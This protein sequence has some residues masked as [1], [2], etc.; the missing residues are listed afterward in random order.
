MSP[1]SRKKPKD[2][3]PRPGDPKPIPGDPTR[4][5]PV[6]K[7]PIW[8]HPHNLHSASY[9]VLNDIVDIRYLMGG[10]LC[11]IKQADL[12][13]AIHMSLPLPP[14][15]KITSFAMT[16]K[17]SNSRSYIKGVNVLELERKKI[18]GGSI[19]S[20][21]NPLNSTTEKEYLSNFDTYEVKG[22]LAL[23]VHLTF[24][25]TDDEIFIG[26]VGLWV[27]KEL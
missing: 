19:V 10:T 16:Y 8:F 15:A 5:T 18:Y 23:Q 17:C 27:I 26:P 24:A 6:I 20:Y 7:L 2:P 11:K 9:E 22:A 12:E 1:R 14:K 13:Y 4:P 3:G 21:G 25:N